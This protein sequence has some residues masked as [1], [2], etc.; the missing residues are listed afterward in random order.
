MFQNVFQ[1]KIIWTINPIII[2]NHASV[3]NDWMENCVSLRERES[4]QHAFEIPL[5]GKFF[6]L[7]GCDIPLDALFEASHSLLYLMNSVSIV[8]CCAFHRRMWASYFGSFYKIQLIITSIARISQFAFEWSIQSAISAHYAHSFGQ[9][10]LDEE[11]SGYSTR[12]FND[13][14][15]NKK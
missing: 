7:I 12:I 5:N 15:W 6:A 14:K 10:M 2:S 9:Q 11:L 8:Y 3:H 13:I 4:F 1:S